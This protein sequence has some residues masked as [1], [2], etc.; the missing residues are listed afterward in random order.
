[1][2]Y[3]EQVVTVEIEYK[4]MWDE[5]SDRFDVHATT[6]KGEIDPKVQ[7]INLAIELGEWEDQE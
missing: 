1:M 6:R 5:Y 3:K 4:V 7:A 2:A